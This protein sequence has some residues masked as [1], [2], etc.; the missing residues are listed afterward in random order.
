[1]IAIV[2][3]EGDRGAA[4]SISRDLVET[5]QGQLAVQIVS[6]SSPT[7]WP[8]SV[9]WDDL[10]I[11]LFHQTEFPEAGRDFAAEFLKVRSEHSLVLPVS[12]D[13][14][15]KMPPRPVDTI[16]ALPYD[17]QARGPSAALLGEWGRCSD[18]NFDAK[19]TEFP[20]LIAQSTEREL[21]VN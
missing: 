1:V 18:L 5:Y 9:S 11:V 6:A 17:D 20:F 10:L 14:D 21:P 7:P 19:I 4:E 15:R 8:E 13:I 2:C 12:L 16:K 3:E